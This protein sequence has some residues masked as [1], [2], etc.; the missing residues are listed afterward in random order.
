MGD[1][2]LQGQE[3]YLSGVSLSWKTYKKPRKDWDHDHCAF[4]GATFSEY[5]GDLH[6][7]YTTPDEYYWIC[8]CCYEDFKEQFHWVAK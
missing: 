2:R 8:K 4:C 3:R 6:E 1:W 7:G 5:E